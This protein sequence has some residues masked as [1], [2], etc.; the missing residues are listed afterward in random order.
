MTTTQVAIGI[1]QIG[2]YVSGSTAEYAE[3]AAIMGDVLGGG[4]LLGGLIL[5]VV[6]AF[7]FALAVA[8]LLGF[9]V[10]LHHRGLST[11]EFIL[12]GRRKRE[13]EETAK[14]EQMRAQRQAEVERQD[15]TPKPS[16]RDTSSDV[17]DC[18]DSTPN[19]AAPVSQSVMIDDSV[20]TSPLPWNGAGGVDPAFPPTPETLP[21][22]RLPPLGAEHVEDENDSTLGC[23]RSAEKTKPQSAVDQIMD[24]QP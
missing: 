2:L 6:V 12:E 13:L 20:R 14:I 5:V 21:P 1:W 10:Y 4:G 23:G 22:G 9:H 11:Y 16:S 15:E 7:V 17:D 19:V 3:R 24:Q 8:H 18:N